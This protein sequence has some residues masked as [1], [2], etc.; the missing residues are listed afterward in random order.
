MEDILQPKPLSSEL[1]PPENVSWYLG[2]PVRPRQL[3]RTSQ[4]RRGLFPTIADAARSSVPQVTMR[5]SSFLD[6]ESRD[7]ITKEEFA[8]VVGDRDIPYDP[9]MTNARA[10]V[11]IMEYERTAYLGQFKS[12]PLAELIGALPVWM[13]DPV[14]I[15][16]IPVGAARMMAA[17]TSKTLGEVLKH[18]SIAGSQVGVAG[19]PLEILVQK[20]A[21]GEIDP[22]MLVLSTLAPVPFMA[23][24]GTGGHLARIGYKRAMGRFGPP[25]TTPETR[26]AAALAA[27]SGEFN[28]NKLAPYRPALDDL[29]DAVLVKPFPRLPTEPMSR[30]HTPTAR[31]ADTFRDYAGGY[32]RWI[33][34]L[35]RGDRT[36]IDMA[37]RLGVDLESP[38]LRGYLRNLSDRARRAPKRAV[39]THQQAMDF[40]AA[41]RGVATSEQV[42][43]LRQSGVMEDADAIARVLDR[44]MG[45]SPEDL[46]RTRQVLSGVTTREVQKGAE[47]SLFY[48]EFK[49]LRDIMQK[50][51]EVR[52]Q[53]EQRLLAAFY[54]D[55]PDGVYEQ[56]IMLTERQISRTEDQ[57]RALYD[58]PAKTRKTKKWKTD[59][60]RLTKEREGLYDEMLSLQARSSPDVRAEM[61]EPTDFMAVLEAARMESPIRDARLGKSPEG[62]TPRDRV[63]MESDATTSL[64]NFAREIGVDVEKI[65]GVA[66]E[67]QSILLRC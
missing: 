21:Y 25:D 50:K 13:F 67:M 10:Q 57:M 49:M 53:D 18:S 45:V 30:V 12:R 62:Q 23:A 58:A 20:Q 5:W 28:T 61:I 3:P 36:A 65:R 16:L 46:A 29:T 41:A 48:G 35:A 59:L 37:G 4:I 64:E 43:R 66:D 44:G 51:P 7:Y 22:T 33:V 56:M 31:L 8:E 14:N 24:M 26:S 19:I 54:R 32:R 17:R 38:A 55:G 27:A 34:D 15:A 6:D 63:M 40:T 39:D 1:R 52:S 42:T 9:R 60:E 47:A 2:H 11:A